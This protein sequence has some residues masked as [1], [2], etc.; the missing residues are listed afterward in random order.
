ML[1]EQILILFEHT[2]SYYNFTLR[3]DVHVKLYVSVQHVISENL[4]DKIRREINFNFQTISSSLILYVLISKKR[5]KKKKICECAFIVFRFWPQS[6]E[7]YNTFNLINLCDVS[8]VILL[9]IFHKKI[10][11]FFFV[12]IKLK[13]KEQ[14][15]TLM[16]YIYYINSLHVYYMTFKK[17]FFSL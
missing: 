15:Q 4:R 10:Y 16:V 6:V 7:K 14:K 9:I 2:F 17:F 1:L 12:E 3:Y 11:L 8:I 5:K 13:R